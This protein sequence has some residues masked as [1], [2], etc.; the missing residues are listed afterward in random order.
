MP[1]WRV[2]HTLWAKLPK[3]LEGVP[4]GALGA[5][6][7]AAQAAAY[8]RRLRGPGSVTPAVAQTLEP[9]ALV[10]TAQDPAVICTGGGQEDTGQ[11][12]RSCCQAPP[13]CADQRPLPL[14]HPGPC[15]LGAVELRLELTPG[16]DNWPQPLLL[17][18]LV[19][20]CA[21]H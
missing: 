16:L 21:W 17:F 1:R 4:G 3:G 20:P 13:S 14:E 15:R 6:H 7:V 5:T 19:S 10:D 2:R 11:Q 12:G 8:A 18:L 9:K